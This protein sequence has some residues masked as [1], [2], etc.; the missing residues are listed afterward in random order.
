MEDIDL[1]IGMEGRWKCLLRRQSS[2]TSS[3]S[4]TQLA[5]E[6]FLRTIMGNKYIFFWKNSRSVHGNHIWRSSWT[7]LPVSG[8][9]MPQP[10][11][12]RSFL[13]ALERLPRIL[14]RESLVAFDRSGR[15]GSV[16]VTAGRNPIRYGYSARRIDRTGW[17]QLLRWFGFENGWALPEGMSKTS[18]GGICERIH[19]SIIRYESVII[20]D[21]WI[22]TRPGCNPQTAERQCGGRVEA[23]SF[24]PE[25]RVVEDLDFSI[26][27]NR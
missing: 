22:E 10:A 6:T 24:F 27:Q 20:A 9:P 14:A 11:E 13:G 17:G 8:S 7:R 1:F 3:P 16:R 19:A 2:I 23:N 25:N 12:V 5:G 4:R 18:S 21:L 26:G 15:P